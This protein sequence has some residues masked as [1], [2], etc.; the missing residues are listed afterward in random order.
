MGHL[1]GG[2][3]QQ[4]A[5]RQPSGLVGDA[6]SDFRPASTQCMHVS[7]YLPDLSSTRMHRNQAGQGQMQHGYLL[8]A[9]VWL[10]QPAEPQFGRRHELHFAA[11]IIIT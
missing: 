6:Y 1:P 2:K 5:Q 10:L 3:V 11:L 7:L 9:Y 8:N 4:Q